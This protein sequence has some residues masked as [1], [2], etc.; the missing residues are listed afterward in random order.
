MCD[1]FDSPASHIVT[2]SA[3][4]DD[5]SG[6]MAGSPKL[7]A[8]FED[9]TGTPIGSFTEVSLTFNNGTQKWEGQLDA[10]GNGGDFEPNDP[11]V[12]IRWYWEAADGE[13]NTSF[14]PAGAPGDFET[15]GVWN[16]D[17]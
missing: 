15:T 17:N 5:P 11:T 10:P 7:W 4:I 13:G 14:F 12:F 6:L 16:C 9:D 3:A 8:V 2:I 1:E